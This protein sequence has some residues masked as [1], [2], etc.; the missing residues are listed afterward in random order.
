MAIYTIYTIHPKNSPIPP[1]PVFATPALTAAHLLMTYGQ[2]SGMCVVETKLK[3][4]RNGLW[5]VQRN[6][7]P[8]YDEYTS[9]VVV[10]RSAEEALACVPR[11]LDD[12][13]D[14]DD[15]PSIRAWAANTTRTATCIGLT[16]V[17][18]P[19]GKVIICDFC[20]G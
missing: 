18:E 2:G 9:C 19:V 11:N 8:V 12:S 7:T 15:Y 20:N 6:D 5:L 3:T 10:A 16:M 1:M 4:L 13:E 14:L 17:D